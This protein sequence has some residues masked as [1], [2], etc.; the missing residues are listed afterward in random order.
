MQENLSSNSYLFRDREDA[1][2]Q[3]FD[4]LPKDMM[5]KENWLLLCL[6]L[7]A[8]VL[9]ELISKKLNIDYDFIFIEPIDAPNND[10]CQIA[11]V[12]ETQEIVMHQNLVDS[13]GITLDYIYGEAKRKYQNDLID[14]QYMYRKSLPLSEIK[15]RNILLIDEGCETGFSTMCALKSAI[16]LGVK[17]ISLATPVIADELCQHMELKVDKVYANYKIK[18]FIEVYY[19][20]ESLDELKRKK[21]KKILEESSRY[22]PFKGEK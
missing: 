9:A 10:E 2:E 1:A 4:I 21:I 19:Y 3:L 8:V 6:S 20:Y 17:K 15:G 7:G 12:S 22:L 5:Q 11:M 14:Y 13:F 18:D 16:K